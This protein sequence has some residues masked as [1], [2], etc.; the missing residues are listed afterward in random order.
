MNEKGYC[1]P[2]RSE[3]IEDSRKQSIS[4]TKKSKK[5]KINELV[6]VVSLFYKLIKTIKT[7]V[8]LK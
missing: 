6:I 8:N 7:N 1:H 2:E 5:V 3:E 4:A